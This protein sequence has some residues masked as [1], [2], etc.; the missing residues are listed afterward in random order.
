MLFKKKNTKEKT[1]NKSTKAQ[2]GKTAVK[3]TKKPAVKTVKTA[4]TTKTTKTVKPQA[5]SAKA[6][7]EKTQDKSD[8]IL[9]KLMAIEKEARLEQ[10]RDNVDNLEDE[11]IAENYGQSVCDADFV[12]LPCSCFVGIYI[13]V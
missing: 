6:K 11:K 3:S 8:Q 1:E 13:I 5:G 12:C 2:P 7:S 9:N 4:K 10:A